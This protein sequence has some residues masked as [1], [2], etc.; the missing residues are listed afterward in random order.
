MFEAERQVV[1]LGELQQPVVQLR[2]V[3]LPHRPNV[4]MLQPT[5]LHGQ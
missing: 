4:G 5:L 1:S 3:V 2:R